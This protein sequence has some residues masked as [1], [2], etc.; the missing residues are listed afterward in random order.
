MWELIAML[1]KY[2]INTIPK[3]VLLLIFQEKIRC[4]EQDLKPGCLFF[5]FYTRCYNIQN[6]GQDQYHDRFCSSNSGKETEL[7]MG[8]SSP[9]FYILTQNQ[10]LTG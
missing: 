8:I 6:H 10:R 1:I 7:H 3:W 9:L 4:M 2:I 5:F